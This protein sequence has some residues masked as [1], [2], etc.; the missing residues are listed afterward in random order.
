[1]DFDVVQ[2]KSDLV[3]SEK[4]QTLCEYYINLPLMHKRIIAETSAMIKAEQHNAN[5][6]MCIDE[7]P[8]EKR[9]WLNHSYVN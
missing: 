3:P 8:M 5:T 9:R 2:T 7:S 4:R 1:M 6:H